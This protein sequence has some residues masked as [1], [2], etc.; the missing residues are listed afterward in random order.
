MI[1]INFINFPSSF[2]Q[3]AHAQL[4]FFNKLAS[5]STI[6]LNVYPPNAIPDATLYNMMFDVPLG[7]MLDNSSYTFA[8]TK[9]AT[10]TLFHIFKQHGY[11]THFFG[12]FPFVH[13]SQSLEMQPH[14]P[15]ALQEFGIDVTHKTIDQG[16][17]SEIDA[18]TL[19]QLKKLH[20]TEKHFIWVNLLTCRDVALCHVDS[21]Q[22]LVPYIALPHT[23]TETPQ[24]DNVSIDRAH[25]EAQWLFQSTRRPTVRDLESFAWDC[26]TA[27][28][29][30]LKN[31]P[32][33]DAIDVYTCTSHPIGLD[34]QS[35]ARDSLRGF[36]T[37]PGTRETITRPC[38]VLVCINHVL[39]SMTVDWHVRQH[40]ESLT[41]NFAPSLLARS[42]I[43]PS[44]NPFTFQCFFFRLVVVH[45]HRTYA[46]VVYMSIADMLKQYDLDLDEF[47]TVCAQTKVWKIALDDAMTFECF[48]LTTDALETTNIY[49]HLAHETRE[50]LMHALKE[51]IATQYHNTINVTFPPKV[52]KS[53][54]HQLSCKE[55]VEIITRFVCHTTVLVEIKGRL[56]MSLLTDIA[57][58]Q[59]TIANMTFGIDKG[60]FLKYKQTL[61]QVISHD[62]DTFYLEQGQVVLSSQVEPPKMQV[63]RPSFQNKRRLEALKKRH[64]HMR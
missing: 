33:H 12:P 63:R 18:Y 36:F 59:C 27:L 21:T 42:Q 46:L 31:I 60:I 2:I 43:Q 51:C 40:T 19:E 23:A 24:S 10:R 30:H 64:E 4:E 50:S 54:P 48:D 47:A 56:T 34:V 53:L 58:A 37:C 44:I 39:K 3:R 49:K 8:N 35:V 26:L 20:H 1:I 55:E 9:R 52:F 38:S 61:Y 13:T 22:S 6:H 11:E 25:K 14:D 16:L 7:S 29:A 62:T 5:K 32:D 17:A 45:K 41:A 15:N 57:R 28:D